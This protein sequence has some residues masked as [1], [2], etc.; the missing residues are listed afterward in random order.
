L[1]IA[2][3]EKFAHVTYFFNG[4]NEKA[5]PREDRVIVQSKNVSSFDKAPEMSA[6]EITDKLVSF[7]EKEKY[8][9]ILVNYANA[10][11]VGHTGN[12]KAAITAIETIDACLG[13]LIKTTLLKNGCLLITA[14]HGNVEEMI[15]AHTGEADTEHSANPVPL[16]FITRENHRGTPR[17][18]APCKIAGLLSDLAPTILELFD[19]EKPKEM[20]GESLLEILE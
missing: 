8:D 19:I 5:Y 15:N 1:R 6:E 7:I 9:F 12:E 3:T 13:N 4:G 17:E 10:D 11:I 18:I 20:T 2:E 16:W 14:D